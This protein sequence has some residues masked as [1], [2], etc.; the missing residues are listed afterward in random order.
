MNTRDSVG[1]MAT[2]LVSGPSGS[3]KSTVGRELQSRGF[4][5][6]ETDFEPDL[7]GWFNN[8]T[9][10]KVTSLPPQPASKEWFESHSWLWNPGKVKELVSNS[11]AEPVFFCGGAYNEKDFYS[12]FDVRFALYADS[13]TLVNRLR[14]RE[15][16]RWVDG[17]P[18]L[19]Q[20]LDWNSR[21]KEYSLNSGAILI[22]STKSTKVITDKI[23]SHIN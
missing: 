16:K 4:K 3:G 19:L 18:A 17:S 7:S 12:L 11:K 2:Y 20:L 6:V 22:N 15:P 9:G 8:R 5:V 21:F 14:I 10:E 13:E 23:L 1:D